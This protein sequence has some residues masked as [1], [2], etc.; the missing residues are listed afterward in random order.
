MDRRSLSTLG[1]HLQTLRLARGWSL[2]QLAAAAGIAKSNLSRL[3]QGNG[4][5][6]LDTIWRLAVQL[7][8]PFGTLVAPL[9]VPLGEEG[10]EVRLLDQGKDT[11]QVDAYWMRCAPHTLR[12]AEAHTPGARE[13]LTL[14]SGQLEAGPEGATTMLSAGDTL[15]FAA[16]RAHLY[17][18]HDAWATLLLTVIYTEKGATP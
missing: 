17:R 15:T 13:S 11:P 4:N 6:T 8:V 5:P 14:I 12:H 9:S 1:Q 3:E 10:V 2:S 18:T 7:K 16:D